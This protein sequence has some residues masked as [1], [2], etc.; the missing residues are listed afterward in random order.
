MAVRSVPVKGP[1][2][3]MMAE[4]FPDFKF[5]S[6]WGGTYCFIREHP[7]YWYDYL[8]V[9]RYFEDGEGDL[10]I[11][12]YLIGS[13]YVPDW[14]EWNGYYHTPWRVTRA[15]G[16]APNFLICQVGTDP[17]EP[18][19]PLAAPGPK[20]AIQYQTQTQ[21]LLPQALEVLADKL[22]RYALPVLE[23]PLLPAQERRLARWRL[24]AEHILPRLETLEQEDPEMF[25]AVKGWQKQTARRFQTDIDEAVPPVM[26]RWREEI[27][28]LPGFAEEWDKSPNLRM[29]VFNWFTHAFF[30]RP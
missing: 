10:S 25:E 2:I 16:P 6:F 3:K 20:A 29:W 13:G 21:K 1:L 23:Q 4:R 28:Q 8:P 14:Y 22:Q 5:S 11:N 27:S 15:Q 24:L 7:G 18:S 19:S 9:D 17:A 26:A 12:W 30:L